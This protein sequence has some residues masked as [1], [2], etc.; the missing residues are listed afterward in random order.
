MIS[1]GRRL[2][3]AFRSFFSILD[4]SRI[5]DDIAAELVKAPPAPE[6]AKAPTPAAPR[7]TFDRATQLLS[8]LQRDGRLLDFVMEDLG[9]YQ[10]AQIGAAARD[11]HAGCRQM[12]A[13]YFTLAPVMASE[14]GQS[15]TVERG[16]DPARIKVVGNVAGEPPYRGI[17]R[18]R[19]WEA[20]RVELP[21][22]PETARS[23]LAPAEVEVE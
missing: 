22:L 9:P 8:L 17:V 18:H 23:I 7:E 15:V 16:A 1:Y 20:T 4:Y 19:G 11:V 13:R 5:P 12:L 14:E 10:D 21:P 2:K 6:P 3:F